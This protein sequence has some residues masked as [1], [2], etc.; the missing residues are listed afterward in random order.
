[1]KHKHQ[2][3]IA[4]LLTVAMLFSIMP[5]S[6]LAATMDSIVPQT[7]ADGLQM[8][9]ESDST[10]GIFIDATT[11]TTASELQVALTKELEKCTTTSAIN[12]T[13]TLNPDAPAGM[14]TAIRRAICDTE[15]VT[16]GSIHLTLGGVTT[17]PGTTNWDGVAFGPGDIY[18]EAGKIE[19]QELVTQLASI[20][21][22]DVTEIGAQAFYFCENLVTVS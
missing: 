8:Q 5:V 18:D 20:N 13:V 22:P 6:A 14:I 19:D 2:K 21:L 15:S 7:Q 12:I 4:I 3:T 11:T 9:A 17:I 1:M 10:S 16:A